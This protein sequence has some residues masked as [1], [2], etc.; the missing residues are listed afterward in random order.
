MVFLLLTQAIG[1]VFV[2]VFSAAYL[3]ALPSDKVLHS[4]PMFSLSLQLTGA[5]FLILILISVALSFKVRTKD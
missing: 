5:L 2:G 3:L 1:A 4:E